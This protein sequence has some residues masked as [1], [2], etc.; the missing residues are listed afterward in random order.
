M[1]RR[2]AALSGF[3]TVAAAAHRAKLTYQEHMHVEDCIEVVREALERT[4]E[5]N[6]Q[7]A[8]KPAPDATSPS[9]PQ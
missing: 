2:Q 4:L 7:F 5:D 6:Y 8:P 9:N 3:E 1:T